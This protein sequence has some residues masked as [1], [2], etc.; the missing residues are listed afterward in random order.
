MTERERIV[1]DEPFAVEYTTRLTE[2]KHE[3]HLPQRIIVYCRLN[4]AS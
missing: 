3:R 1:P 2:R 4:V